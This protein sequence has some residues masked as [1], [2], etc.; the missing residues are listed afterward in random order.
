M[1]KR[2]LKRFAGVLVKYNDKVLL[3]KRSPNNTL[4]NIWSVPGGGIE[5]GEK[6]KETAIR[7]FYE[8]T[9]IE[10][11]NEDDIR[12]IGVVNNYTKNGDLKGVMYIYLYES[13]IMLKPNL[14]L[15]KDGHEHSECGYFTM[16]ELPFDDYKDQLFKLI[17]KIF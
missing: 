2:K 3:C 11:N 8:E 14:D 7:E 16:K 9:N 5:P 13:D 12:L 10:L 4:P 1:S 17:L 15:A 6:P